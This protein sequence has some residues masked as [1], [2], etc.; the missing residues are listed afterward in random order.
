MGTNTEI[1]N[2]KNLI[3]Y[4]KNNIIQSEY[5]SQTA[6]PWRVYQAIHFI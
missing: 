5:D 1:F 6:F 3:P 2:I 4:K